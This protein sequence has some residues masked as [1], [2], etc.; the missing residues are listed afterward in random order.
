MAARY[1]GP[2]VDFA[3]NGTVAID[4]AKSS[5]GT[6]EACFPIRGWFADC[7]PRFRRE[8]LALGRPKFYAAG[9][10]I[11]QAGEVGQDVFGISSGVVTLRSRLTHPDAVLLHMLRP[12]EWFGTVP[13]LLQRSRRV[14]AVARTDV[15]L[16]RV[17]GDELRALLRRRPEWFAELGR[18]AISSMDL[19]MQ[20]AAD[21]LIRDASARCAAVLLRLAGRRWASG[22]EADLPSE[23]P[24]SQT[25]LAMLCNV[26]RNT[27]SRVVREFSSRRLVTLDY[28][29]LTVNEPARLRV[30]ADAG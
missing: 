22:P 9:S 19:A 25:E 5:G 27:F 4:M 1:H 26:S 24:A 20:I 7:P 21:L 10:V 23:I 16:L 8:F 13:V 2:G 17:P 14:T 18:D 6:A 30:V 11:Y 29:S 28:R 12:G 15:N 3:Q